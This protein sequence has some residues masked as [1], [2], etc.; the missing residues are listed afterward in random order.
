MR[1]GCWRY[2]RV[3]WLGTLLSVIS[4]SPFVMAQQPGQV[5]FKNQVWPLLETHCFSCHGPTRQEGGLRLD[6]R[7]VV[8]KG[9]TSGPA[10]VPGNLTESMLYQRVMSDAAGDQMP[11]EAEALGEE[12]LQLLRRWIEQGADWPSDIGSDV[13]SVEVHWAYQRVE[14]PRLPMPRRNNW[15]R[16]PI[17][18]FVLDRL[19]QKE[20]RPSPQAEPRRLIRRLYLDLVGVP[21]TIE[22][23]EAFAASTAPRAYEQLV[24]K[25]L[26]SP[27]YGERWARTWLDLAR[28]AD[29]NGYQADQYRNIWPYRDWVI[30]AMNTDMPF[31]QFTLEQLAGDLLPAASVDQ[32]VATGFHR[33]TTCNVEAGVDPEANRVN[34]VIDRVNTTGTVWLGT[35]ISCVQCHSHKYDPFLQREYYQLFAF[36]NNTPLEVE[37][38]GV[39]YNFFGPKMD[40]PLSEDQQVRFATLD[41]EV[42]SLEVRI[43]DRKEALQADRQAWEAELVKAARQAPLWHPLEV[44]SFSSLGGA[45]HEI[46][47]DQSVLVSGKRPE[48]DTYTVTLQSDVEQIS[49]LKLE[50]LTHESLPGNGP[51]RHDEQRPNFVLHELKVQ[52]GPADGD[53]GLEAVALHTPRADFS[54]QNLKVAGILDG[55]PET[56][57]AINPQFGKPHFATLLTEKKIGGPGWRFVVTLEQNY[58]G[59]R[60]IGRLRISAMTGTPTSL[61]PE[62]LLAI[63]QKPIAKRSDEEQGKLNEHFFALDPEIM[64]MVKQRD[65][66][67]KQLE[68][69]KPITTLVMIEQEQ[70]RETHVLRRGDFKDPMDQVQP[71]T[72]G[73]L[74]AMKK[75]LSADRVGLARWLVDREN[76]LTA[77]VTV[78]RWWADIFGRGIV[79]TEED[80]G[81]QGDRPTH[82][83][84]LDWL[85]VEFMEKG[86]SM[87]HV[88]RLIVN[89]ATYQQ[90]SR[91]SARQLQQDPGNLLLG[92]GPRIRLSAEM[93]RD[94]ALQVSGLLSHKMG[95]PPVYPPQPAGIW[96]HV[97]RNEPQYNTSTGTDRFRRGIYVFWRRSAPY[98]SFTNFDAPDRASCVVRRSRTNTPLQ[99]LTLLNDSA[100]LEI[101]RH[102][103][104]R[105]IGQPG[106]ADDRQRMAHAFQRVVSRKASTRELDTL[107][108][109]YRAELA[110]FEHN[111]E[112]ASAALGKTSVAAADQPRLAAWFSIANVLLNLD[113]T[114]TKG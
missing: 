66:L 4:W 14:R 7:Q 80:F 101:A 43:H 103:A 111:P 107:M 39:T 74:P 59:C 106:M 53:S 55:D 92:R 105:I 62:A 95:G 49:G 12:Q 75:E 29:S 33:L 94:N 63:V 23:V 25:L 61:V 97:G 82:P 77:R 102:L 65:G 114:I 58:G 76:P 96:R 90:S 16:N 5:D 89:S 70:P 100:Y 54:Q 86:W 2:F 26:A 20:L 27:L 113:E 79:A 72:P 34:Q 13:E 91:V 38:N 112:I 71:G 19:S 60:T 109:L 44:E 37:G 57:W 93:I 10:I 28:Y 8:I 21:P 104:E 78:N 87:K 22:E 41:A 69:I 15:I 6:A 99:A 11:L 32:K 73:S 56:G 47:E 35:T 50:A 24:E 51:G 88:H 67:Q 36:F 45:S 31:D 98:P 42:K 17:D 30:R 3:A 18:A 46:L 85:A 84:L 9:G 81:T 48:R 68:N 40:L 52:A 110:R 1:S 108:E 64:A 83:D